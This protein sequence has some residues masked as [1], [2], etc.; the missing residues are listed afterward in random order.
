MAAAPPRRRSARLAGRGP[1]VQIAIDRI[2]VDLLKFIA[3]ELQVL[4]CAQA[5]VDLRPTAGTDQRTGDRRLSEH[6]RQRHLRQALSSLSRDLVERA[7]LVEIAFAEHGLAERALPA[8]SGSVGDALQIPGREQPLRLWR[9]R[10]AG[11]AFIV[12]QFPP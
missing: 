11:D 6:P 3:A 7:H 8:R 12:E 1:D 4:Q 9:E 10:D 2:S 5:L